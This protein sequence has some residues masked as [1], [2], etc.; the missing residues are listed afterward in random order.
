MKRTISMLAV[1]ALFVVAVVVMSSVYIVD[2]REKALVT[3]FGE[4]VKVRETPG[5]GL[6]IPFWTTSSPMTRA[7][8]VCRPIRWR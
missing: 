7:S 5:M 2:V 8:S 1:P 3:R 6:K 4:V